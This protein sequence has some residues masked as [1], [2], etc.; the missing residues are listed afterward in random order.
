MRGWMVQREQETL[1]GR[2]DTSVEQEE[3]VPEYKVKNGKTVRTYVKRKF[4]TRE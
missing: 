1:A 2:D 4:K 3:L